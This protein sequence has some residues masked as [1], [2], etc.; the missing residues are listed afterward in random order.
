[1]SQK[2]AV[3]YE[4][5]SRNEALAL[6]EFLAGEGIEA[7]VAD[8]AAAPEQWTAA[9]SGTIVVL[10]A[11]DDEQ[12]AQKVLERWQQRSA[13]DALEEEDAAP[14]EL[15]AWPVCEQCG[16]RRTTRCPICHTLG[17]DFPLA[18]LSDL[19]S[20]EDDSRD[21]VVCTMCD[22]PFLPRWLR[23]CTACGH[24]HG[25]GIVLADDRESSEP[26]NGRVIGMLLAL[27]ALAIVSIVYFAMIA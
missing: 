25:A 13:D 1:M 3:L 16:A 27:L 20:D 18:E 10:V 4:G 6:R 21:A 9:A 17:D 22:E 5:R 24:D 7:V 14:L 2:Q 19:P 15:A 26:I 12:A 8:W 11:A 23:T